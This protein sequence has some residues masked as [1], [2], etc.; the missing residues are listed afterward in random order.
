[1]PTS[2][3]DRLAGII[4]GTAVGDGLGLPAEGIRPTRLQRLWP[5]PWRHHFALGHSM[6]SDDT[7]HTFFVAQSLLEQP[8][9]AEAFVKRL[10]SRLR[11]WFLS[12]PAGIGKAT[13]RACLK[14]WIGFPPTSSGVWSA[15]NGPAM[16]VALIGGYFA[17][18]EARLESFVRAATRVT[19]TDTRALVGARAVARVAAWA[20]RHDAAQQPEIDELLRMLASLPAEDQEWQSLLEKLRKAAAQ[21]LSVLD[22]AASLGA[23]KGVSGYVY[24]TVPVAVY[25]WWRHYGDVRATIEAVIRCGGDTDTGGAIAGAL[26]GAT[27]GAAGIPRD[28]LQGIWDWPRSVRLLRETAERLGRQAEEH[29]PLGPVRYFWP[30]VL[31]RNLLFLA[32]VLLHGFRRLLPPY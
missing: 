30:G 11:W 9:D 5:G 15:G 3:S 27:T 1:M 12:L 25:A 6:L 8:D 10:A 28:W 23:T 14:L 24:Q 31:P 13:L 21:E 20:V 2:I 7:E 32:V 22:F 19:H 16:R 17:E 26:A 18:D 29:Q 4:L